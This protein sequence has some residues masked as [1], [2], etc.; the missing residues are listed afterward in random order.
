MTQYPSAPSVPWKLENFRLGHEALF[1]PRSPSNDESGSLFLRAVSLKD[2][3][4]EHKVKETQMAENSS[5]SSNSGL[6]FV[7]GGL[8]VVVAIGV[9]LFYGGYIGG[10][11]SKTTTE[12]T[13]S[14]A[15]ASVG[16]TT[17][18]TDKTK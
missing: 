6:S 5:G 3:F 15:P 4:P 16:T 8:V 13:T 2:I 18:T 12:Q 9:F 11:S 14:S 1:R 7:V 10:H 17:T